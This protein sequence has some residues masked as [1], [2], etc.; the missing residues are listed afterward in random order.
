MTEEK[1]INSTTCWRQE[2]EKIQTSSHGALALKTRRVLIS[3]YEYILG[4]L[5]TASNSVWDIV[6]A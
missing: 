6:S 2:E 1:P 3:D 4:A 5:I